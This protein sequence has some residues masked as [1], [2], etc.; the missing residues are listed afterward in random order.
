MQNANTGNETRN[1]GECEKDSDCEKGVKCVDVFDN[2]KKVL[3]T[4]CDKDGIFKETSSLDKSEESLE[5]A[6]ND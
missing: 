3:T 6:Q 1:E 5:L 2:K 4:E